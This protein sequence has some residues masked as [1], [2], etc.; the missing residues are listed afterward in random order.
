MAVLL[1]SMRGRFWKGFWNVSF[2]AGM[3]FDNKPNP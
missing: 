2:R 3:S 1:K